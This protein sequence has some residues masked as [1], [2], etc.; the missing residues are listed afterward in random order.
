MTDAAGRIAT[1]RTALTK[2]IGSI[3]CEGRPTGNE[4]IGH[5]L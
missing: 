1:K 2:Y 5:G 4:Q 3:L